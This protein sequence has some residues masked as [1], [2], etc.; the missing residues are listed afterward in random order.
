VELH[1]LFDVDAAVPLLSHPAGVLQ[2]A[3]TIWPGNSRH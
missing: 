3:H 1:M 2:V